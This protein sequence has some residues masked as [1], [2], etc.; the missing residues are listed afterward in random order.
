MHNTCITYYLHD[1]I[2][3]NYYLRL[4]ISAPLIHV[5]LKI[6]PALNWRR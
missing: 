1:D 4:M 5:I 3:L 6:L 2:S